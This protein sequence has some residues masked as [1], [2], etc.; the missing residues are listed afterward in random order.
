[1]FS[2]DV[3]FGDPT[4]QEPDTLVGGDLLAFAG[5]EPAVV[6]AVPTTQQA[7]RLTAS[8]LVKAKTVTVLVFR[9]VLPKRAPISL[10]APSTWLIILWAMFIYAPASHIAV[11]VYIDYQ[12]INILV[13]S[14]LFQLGLQNDTFYQWSLGYVGEGRENSLRYF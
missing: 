3:G 7:I 10:L 2:L 5:I 8:E 1:V 6:L 14:G 12:V 9:R 4:L 13:Y 11:I